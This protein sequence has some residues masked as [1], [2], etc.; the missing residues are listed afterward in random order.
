MI[1]VAVFN[2]TTM[3]WVWSEEVSMADAVR[4]TDGVR[5]W[6]ISDPTGYIL[7]ANGKMVGDLVSRYKSSRRSLRLR[8]EKY[9]KKKK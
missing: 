8:H 2:E 6:H 4:V 9:H 3:E 5:A 7:Y 1:D